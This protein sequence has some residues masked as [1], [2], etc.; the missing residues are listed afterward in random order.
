M[1][2][3]VYRV[4]MFTL[5][6]CIPSPAAGLSKI[7]HTQAHVSVSSPRSAQFPWARGGGEQCCEDLQDHT[8]R[9]Q[10]CGQLRVHI[11]AHLAVIASES[12]WVT[13]AVSLHVLVSTS[14]LLGSWWL[15]HAPGNLETSS[16]LVTI[17]LRDWPGLISLQ[18]WP[19]LIFGTVER[20]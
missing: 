10:V 19:S 1:A 7:P 17:S 8:L 11:S 4:E 14:G 13:S 18:D 20:C 2:I 3:S 9:Q 15:G 16:S 12:K 6:A 5:Q